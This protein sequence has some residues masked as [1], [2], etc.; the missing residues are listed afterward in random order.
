LKFPLCP[1]YF[2]AALIKVTTVVPLDVVFQ[3]KTPKDKKKDQ[4]SSTYLCQISNQQ[5]VP[6][7]GPNYQPGKLNG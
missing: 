4:R 2:K 1:T 6:G 5:T 7:A 3:D